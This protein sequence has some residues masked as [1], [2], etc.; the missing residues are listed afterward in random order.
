MLVSAKLAHFSSDSWV[1]F[2]GK[3]ST[4]NQTSLPEHVDVFRVRSQDSFYSALWYTVQFPTV[5]WYFGTLEVSS[6]Y[7]LSGVHDVLL[8]VKTM[9]L[10]L[11]FPA[12]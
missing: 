7:A 1:L 6:S 12:C 5:L 9:P 10:C 4:D 8:W 2:R 11:M 3:G